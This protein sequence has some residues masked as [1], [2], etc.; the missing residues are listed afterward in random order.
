MVRKNLVDV[1]FQS[2]FAV[3]RS[4]ILHLIDIGEIIATIAS[5]RGGGERAGREQECSQ[6]YAS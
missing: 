1:L 2:G 3:D 5:L 6:G 4:A